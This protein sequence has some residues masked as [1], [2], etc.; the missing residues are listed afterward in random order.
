MP[1]NASVLRGSFLLI[2]E[3][4]PQLMTRFFDLL[5]SRYPA[6]AAMFGQSPADRRRHE[7]QVM[8]GIVAV[9][10]GFEDAEWLEQNLMLRGARHAFYGVPDE[11]YAWVNECLA[12]ALIEAA[13]QAW[14]PKLEKLWAEALDMTQAMILKGAAHGRK[15]SV[16]GSRA[17]LKMVESKANDSNP[18]GQRASVG[19]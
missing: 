19:A 10:D 3:A 18:D 14:N 6:S 13:G 17:G 8:N 16:V 15:E 5:F 9:L 1:I 4:S 2:A 12:L 11:M 7:A